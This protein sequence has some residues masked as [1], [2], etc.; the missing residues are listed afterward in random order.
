MNLLTKIVAEDEID[1]RIEQVFQ[2][3]FGQESPERIYFEQGLDEAYIVDTGNNDVRTEGMSYGMMIAVQMDL[4]EMFARLWNWVQRYMT[5]PAADVKNAGYFIWS[6]ST[7]G[8]FLGDGP[9][10]D[11]EEFFAAS[12]LLA[13][14]RWRKLEYGEAARRLLHY[15]VHKYEIDGG[16]PMFEPES[17]YIRYVPS[18]KLTDP[19]YHLP[20]FLELFAASGNP[21]D[22]AFFLEAA[23]ASRLYLAKAADA[24][25]GLTAEYA[26]YAGNPYNIDGHWTF[27]SDAYR[28]AANVGLDWS[29]TND[30]EGQRAIAL[31]IQHFFEPYLS[32]DI[33]KLPVFKIDGSALTAVEQNVNHFPPLLVH[34][35]VGLWATLAQA[36]LASFDL[37]EVLATK[38]LREF[39]NLSLRTGKYRYYDNLLYLF[40]LLALSGRYVSEWEV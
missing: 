20:H 7:K 1:N 18:L 2:Q 4:P 33:Y 11:G 34:H 3:M 10:P 37:D 21:D 39:W 14:R 13:E 15:M 40:A 19:S 30:D 27:F 35:P 31:K 26:D 28:T 8:E 5:A 16:Q 12:L 25:T 32:T 36:S 38:W 24:Q 9:A 29:W 22:R 17:K 23:R 6:C